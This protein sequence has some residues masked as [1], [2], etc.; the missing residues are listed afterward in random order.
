MDFKE[1]IYAR[2]SVR[3]YIDK[4]IEDE[5]LDLIDSFIQEC[6]KK[7]GL[8]MQ[9]VRNEKNAFNS[10]M[11]HYGSFENV[12]N[13]IA[14]IGKK[15]PTLEETCGYYGQKVVLYI[16]TLGLNTCWVAL[17]YQKVENAY[18][19]QDK[20]KLVLVISVGYGQNQGVQ[21]KSKALKQLCDMKET[22]PEWYKT[23]VECALLAPTAL[24]QQYFYIKRKDNVV[25]IK[26]KFGI[27]TKLDLGIVKCNFE[28][29]AGL[30]NFVWKNN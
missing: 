22:D 7:S 17:S 3:K 1:A 20:E 26:N 4:P 8:N 14:V 5:K 2:H 27:L 6:N 13:Y 16:Q 23:G 28:I 19:L 24:N 25:S 30:D 11:A 21:H 12:N 9:L 29:G 15:S 18:T 10:K